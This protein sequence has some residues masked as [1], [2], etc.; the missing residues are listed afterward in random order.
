MAFYQTTIFHD[1]LGVNAADSRIIA[2][3]VFTFQTL[4]APVGVLTVDRFG[5]R[6]LLMVAA[7]GMGTCLSIV[8]G[9][10]PHPD[11]RSAII[12]AGIFIY[13]FCFF[14]S[15]GYLGLTFLYATEVAP[16]SVRMPITAISTGTAWLFN[17]VI[18]EITPVA[19]ADIHARYYIVF[20]CINFAF[21][22]PCKLSPIQ[23][24]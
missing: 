18:A 19:F 23:T 5:R 11:D 2:A 13:I 17:F 3:G 10:A 4:C 9:T 21:I 1:Y 7:L 22:F 15:L 6:K 14:L 12:V 16:L 8:A 24:S 20:V